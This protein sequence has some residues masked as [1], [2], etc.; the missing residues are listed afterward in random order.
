M[1]LAGHVSGGAANG[2]DERAGGAQ[3][4]FLVRVEDGHEG[5]LGQV[6]AL[7]QQVDADEHVEGTQAQL[8]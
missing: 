7:T 1:D 6:Q 2:L 8:A 5:D 3:E 4:T